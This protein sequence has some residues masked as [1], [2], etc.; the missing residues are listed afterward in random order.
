MSEQQDSQGTF[1]VFQPESDRPVTRIWSTQRQAEHVA[2]SM[3][4]KNPGKPFLVMVEVCR[5]VHCYED[6][7][8]GGSD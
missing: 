5:F 4:I 7:D 2:E 6:Y 8:V 1:I 3:S